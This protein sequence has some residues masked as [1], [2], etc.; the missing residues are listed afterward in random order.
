MMKKAAI[1]ARVSSQKQK[2]EETIDS[3]VNALIEFGAK[4]GYEIPHAYFFLDNGVSGQDLQRPAL[5]ELRDMIRTESVEAVLIY[6]PDRLARS[7]PHQLV[8]LEEFRRYGVRVVFIKNAPQANTPEAIMFNH[9]QGIFAEYERALILDR[10][11]RGRI[12]KAKQGDLSI[13]PNM[14]YGYRRIKKER[15]TIIEIVEHEAD[16]VRKIFKHYVYD[17]LSL[18]EIN[19]RLFLDGV[20]SPKGNSHWHRSTIVQILKNRAY[21]GSA[22]YGK[23][24]KDEGTMEKIRYFKSGKQIKPKYARKM[25]PEGDWFEIK[26]PPIINESDFEQAQE[27][28]IKNK[29]LAL[30]NT[31]EPSLLQGLVICGECG[32]PF[33][34]KNR[35]RQT[36][37]RSYYY[38]RSHLDSRLTKC[39]NKWV[40][41]EELDELVYAEVIQLLQN[42]EILLQELQRRR[43]ESKETEEAKRQEITIRKDKDKL[44]KERDRLLDAYQDGLLDLDAL[45]KRNQGLDQKRNELD[46]SMQALQAA[47]LTTE[48]ES[49]LEKSFESILERIKKSASELTFKDKQQLIRLIVEKVVVSKNEVKIVHCISPKNFRENGQLCCGD[50]GR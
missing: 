36:G 16:I 22:F 30:R 3:Q 18:N 31:R 11:R 34:K 17:R 33:Y 38:C 44:T 6:A 26:L 19:R 12:H 10:S 15:E 25:R 5:D 41:Q 47:K 8:L 20:K 2:D 7:Y 46:K 24:Q 37:S 9:F 1:Y 49:G 21:V 48:L 29:E 45:R 35:Q 39:S 4:E 23:T 42:P 28:V 14:P 43:D 27:Y 32:Y 40:R 50:Q 13:L